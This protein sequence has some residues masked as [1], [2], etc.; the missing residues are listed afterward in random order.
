MRKGNAQI[1]WG[2]FATNILIDMWISQA[3][4]CDVTWPYK[5][6]LMYDGTTLFELM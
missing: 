1:N 3:S 5:F 6:L 4:V 2:Q